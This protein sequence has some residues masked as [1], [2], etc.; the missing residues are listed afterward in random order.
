[1]LRVELS[2]ATIDFGGSFSLRLRPDDARLAPLEISA[3]RS[4]AA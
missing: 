4:G 3:Y 1:M 2:L